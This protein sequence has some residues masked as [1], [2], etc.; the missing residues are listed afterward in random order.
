MSVHPIIFSGPMVRA[1]LDG[2]KTMTR[3]VIPFPNTG[4][5][6]LMETGDGGWWPYKSMDGESSDDGT[7]CETPMSCRYGTSGDRLWVKETAVI[8][9]KLWNDGHDCNA[10]DEEGLPRIVQYLS[11]NP[12]RDA[13]NDYKLKASPSIFMP[14]WAS[15]ITLE[16]TSLRVEQLQEITEADARAEGVEPNWCGDLKGWNPEEHGWINYLQ[17]CEDSDP[18]WTAKDSFQTL[19]Q[20]INAKRGFGWDVNPWLWVLTFKVV[21]P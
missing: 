20:S 16:L 21:R 17:T 4:A 9:P 7:G 1:I 18:C 6:V 5:F 10:R 13:A 11:T 3:R 15:R 2:R 8:A 12:N 14:R 19:W